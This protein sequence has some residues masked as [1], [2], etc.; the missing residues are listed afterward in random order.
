MALELARLT[1]CPAKLALIT[2]SVAVTVAAGQLVYTMMQRYYEELVR[3]E[4]G[5]SAVRDE[6]NIE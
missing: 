2:P 5:T 6:D 1:C 4:C 3:E